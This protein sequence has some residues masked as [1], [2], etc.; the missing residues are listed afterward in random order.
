MAGVGD[1]GQ[2][3]RCA[4][5]EFCGVLGAFDLSTPGLLGEWVCY[6]R[7]FEAWRWVKVDG[8]VSGGG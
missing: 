5:A 2:T 8:G 6:V 4:S 3:V 1:S 7:L